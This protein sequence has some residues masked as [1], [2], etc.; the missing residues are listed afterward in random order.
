[1]ALLCMAARCTHALHGAAVRTL[2]GVRPAHSGGLDVALHKRRTSPAALQHRWTTHLAA[3]GDAA[4]DAIDADAALQTV[5]DARWAPILQDIRDKAG[6]PGAVAALRRAVEKY[7]A[8][9][10]A[11]YAS[12]FPF[13][14]DEYQIEA[15]QH[16]R[17]D[18]NVIVSAPTGSGKTVAGE[19]AIAYA[20]AQD[21]RVLYTT[22]LKALS[23]QKFE[24]FCRFFGSENVGLS[25]GDSGVRRDAPVVVMTTEIYRN[26]L[27]ED[28]PTPVAVVFDEFH[29]MNDPSRGTV[30]EESVISSSVETKLVALSATVSNDEQL[31]GWMRK[32]HGPTEVVSSSF[33]P[34]PLKYE[35][36]CG[37]LRDV[38]PLFRAADVGPG[39]PRESEDVKNGGARQRA[40][41]RLRLN[42]LLEQV[43]DR[44]EAP[45]RRGRRKSNDRR[46]RPPPSAMRCAD[47]ARDL[48][49]RDLLPAIFFVF[50]RRGCEE[51]AKRVGSSLQL[52]SEE[53]ETEARQII[54]KWALDNEA[55][56]S[57]DSENDRIQLLTRG[58]AAHHAG[59]LPQYK[60]LVEDLF[61]KGLVKACFA[62][63]TLAA[64]VN[65]PARTTII[66]SL[67]KR[68]DDGI[69]PL[70]TAGLLQ[71]AGRAGRRGKDKAG[72]VLVMRGHRNGANDADLARRILLAKVAPISSH[73][74]PS[75]GM[76]CALLRRHAGSLERCQRLV[77]RSFGS[78]LAKRGVTKESDVD[79]YLKLVNEAQLRA[80][81]YEKLF[82]DPATSVDVLAREKAL[83]REAQRDLLQSPI[84]QLPQEQQKQVLETRRE[85]KESRESPDWRSFVAITSVLR[86][87]DAIDEDHTVTQLGALVASIKG[88]NELLLAL[89]LLDEA[90]LE[91]ATQGSPDEFAALCSAF[92]SEVG[93]RPG[94]F[95]DYGPTPKV[96]R[97]VDELWRCVLQPLAEAQS[98]AGLGPDDGLHLRLDDSA[99]GLVEAW[100]SG[101]VSWE[102]LSDSTSLDHGDLIRL[103][104]RTLDVLRTTASLDAAILPAEFSPIR[105]VARRAAAAIDRPPVHDTTYDAIFVPDDEYVAESG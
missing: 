93:S 29:Y 22:P 75:Y 96:R 84:A 32:V 42:P 60:T 37:V 65:L 25:T 52:L 78:Y 33:R 6:Q 85:R 80:D 9:P 15:L 99:A 2:R 46:E 105:A 98:E 14:L 16:L 101:A 17:N 1:M 40:K 47:V 62:T 71:M 44:S 76:A 34:V 30:W 5:S 41:K 36:A 68:G 77:E 12:I 35:F 64:G 88:D 104:R 70:T 4:V 53:E 48:Q 81:V 83:L 7:G 20:L 8:A 67:K 100:A 45:R 54:Q 21:K 10:D 59:L 3:T 73:F 43:M 39:S 91:V 103:L 74:A 57:L 90:T 58:V 27:Y 95:V 19:L 94:A 61:K 82:D 18:S 51:E 49:R 66:T 89:A 50:S 79:T 72:T 86:K 63:E 26:M 97:A 31:K 24:D 38:V 11:A 13:E 23:N 28:A 69:E 55:V 102:Q 56:A 92:V 87:F